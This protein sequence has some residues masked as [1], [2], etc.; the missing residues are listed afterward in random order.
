[1][2]M[3]IGIDIMGGDFAP[4]S[5]VKGAIAAHKAWSSLFEV[6]WVGDE[7]TLVSLITAEGENPDSYH[8]VHAPEVIDMAASPVR[9]L[10]EK[11]QSSIA[12][13]YDLLASG[14]I[15]GFC[16]AGNSGAMLV[17]SV[18][19]CGVIREDIRPCL[20]SLMPKLHGG[21]GIMLD[22]GAIADTKPET[23]VDLAILGSTY[24]KTILGIEK[25]SVALLSIGEEPEKGNVTTVAGH[26]L[27]AN[28]PGL[29]F[30]GN[31]EGRDLFDEH[32]Q[33]IVTGGFTGNVVM[34]L[35]EK[36]F[37]I[38]RERGL[39][40]DPFFSR[41][42]YEMYGGSPILGVKK[43]AVVGHGISSPL[44][45]QNMIKLTYDIAYNRLSEKIIEALTL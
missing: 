20:I 6:V 15:D 45:I 40:A 31:I 41:L 27:L 29:H 11:P 39:G 18:F 36:F 2:A 22:V 16:S 7:S 34:K 42:N 35:S 9:A 5:A 24:A 14:Q 38:G 13:G 8:I 10:A 32:I 17:G 28:T 44:A 1:M 4:H 12:V 37:D 43:A 30:I 3:K 26:K 19:K 25:P 21:T 23:L 33:V